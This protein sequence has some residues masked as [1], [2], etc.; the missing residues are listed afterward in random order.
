MMSR[1]ATARLVW[2]VLATLW[3]ASPSLADARGSDAA[4]G[5]GGGEGDGGAIERLEIVDRAIAHHGG[6]LYEET[7]SQL[8]LCSKSGCFDVQTSWDRAG[9][10]VLDVAGKAREGL[11][12][13]RTTAQT[14]E[15]WRDGEPVPVTPES[16]QGLRDWAMARVYFCFLPYRLNDPSVFKQDLGIE[17]WGGRPLHKVK[18]TFT[19]GTSTDAE[20]E[21]LYW[22][23]P[24]SGRV[25]LLAYSYETNGGGI[26][27]RKAI[28]HRRVG[29]I[30]FF[31]QENWGF[32]G[33]GLSL[34]ELDA[35]TVA[36]R[37]RHISTVELANIQVDSRP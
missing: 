33:P 15:R 25:E 2:A 28:R 13:V 36:S 11:R 16:E 14:V 23:D 26:R 29:G 31:D 9:Q 24:D 4:V 7:S 32:D 10:P 34:D 22:F 20:D 6:D 3:L 12:R 27:F 5:E 17:D 18:V 21:Y 8:D 37:L 30:L 1:P 35:E 19:P